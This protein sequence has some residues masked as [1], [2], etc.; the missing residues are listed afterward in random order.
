MSS[1]GYYKI[2]NSDASIEIGVSADG[3]QQITSCTVAWFGERPVEAPKLRNYISR[4][5][6]GHVHATFTSIFHLLPSNL[7]RFA[8]SLSICQSNNELLQIF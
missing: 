8:I 7:T 4:N 5:R 6:W 3:Q 2:K 1:S